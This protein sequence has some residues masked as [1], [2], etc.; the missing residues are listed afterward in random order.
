MGRLIYTRNDN[1]S[2]R[3]SLAEVIHICDCGRILT[4]KPGQVVH[5]IHCGCRWDGK[6]LE[7]PQIEKEQR[8]K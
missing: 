8:E 4:R 6:K 3:M 5:C 7:S 1:K 2:G